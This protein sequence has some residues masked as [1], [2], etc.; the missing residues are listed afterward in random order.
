MQIYLSAPL[1]TLT[2]TA[3]FSDLKIRLRWNCPPKSLRHISRSWKRHF[4][5]AFE[6]KTFSEWKIFKKNPGNVSLC[7]KIPFD[8]TQKWWWKKFLLKNFHSESHSESIKLWNFIQPENFCEKNVQRFRLSWTRWCWHFLRRR[9]KKRSETRIS[10][11][12]D[13]AGSFQLQILRNRHRI[14]LLFKE[15]LSHFSSLKNIRPIRQES[16]MRSSR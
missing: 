1:I 7:S 4:P 14:F 10:S 15:K 3:W 13:H 9:C 2:R 8:L 11:N 5:I 12:L 16:S 6:E